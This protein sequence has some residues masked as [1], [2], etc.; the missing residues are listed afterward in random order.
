MPIAL[1]RRTWLVSSRFAWPNKTLLLARDP[2]LQ[3]LRPPAIAIKHD[4]DAI[5]KPR[6]RT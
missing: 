3:V 2:D 6:S 1:S 4:V 5:R